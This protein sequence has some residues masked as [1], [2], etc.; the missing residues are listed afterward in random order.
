MDRCGGD[1]F[2]SGDADRTHQQRRHSKCHPPRAARARRAPATGSSNAVGASHPGLQCRLHA[3]SGDT[4][5]RH[6][7]QHRSDPGNGNGLPRPAVEPCG[8]SDS[9]DRDLAVDSPHSGDSLSGLRETSSA[10]SAHCFDQRQFNRSSA[11]ALISIKNRAFSARFSRIF[12]PV[13]PSPRCN[14][15]R[16]AVFYNPLGQKNPLSVECCNSHVRMA[17]S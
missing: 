2:D 5:Q 4:S 11:I 13:R 12:S 10:G 9:D 17:G 8:N 1:L 14:C 3:S 16:S 6:C 15:G 7:V